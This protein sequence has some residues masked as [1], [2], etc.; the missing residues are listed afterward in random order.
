MSSAHG[1]TRAVFGTNGARRRAKVR[2]TPERKTR[3]GP[4]HDCERHHAEPHRPAPVKHRC[5]LAHA[6]RRI[7][8]VGT[9]AAGALAQGTALLTRGA[10]RLFAALGH[11]VLREVLL[12]NGRRADLLVLTEDDRLTIG[13]L[14]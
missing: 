1:A 2:T 13:H 7:S 12:P 11:S 3:L 6:L 14:E 8:G 5:G 10:A 9:E 4:S